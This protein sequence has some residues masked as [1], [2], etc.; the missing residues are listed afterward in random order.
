MNYDPTKYDVLFLLMGSD[1][2]PDPVALAAAIGSALTPYYAFP[3]APVSQMDSPRWVTVERLIPP[4]PEQS[5]MVNGRRVI[6]GGGA[7]LPLAVYVAPSGALATRLSDE[8]RAAMSD[9]PPPEDAASAAEY[10]RLNASAERTINGRLEFRSPYRVVTG[11]RWV[12]QQ[13]NPATAIASRLSA[14]G[15]V[16]GDGSRPGP[17]RTFTGALHGVTIDFSIIPYGQRGSY[18]LQDLPFPSTPA[19]PGDEV[20]YSSGAIF[21]LLAGMGVGA[22]LLAGSRNK[23]GA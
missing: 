12:L 20:T 8:A 1:E 19:L 15:A 3:F 6:S 17:L 13:R 10:D 16:R 11:V 9:A 14:K 2:S 21:L 18:P 4:T 7:P 5:E 22:A 23:E